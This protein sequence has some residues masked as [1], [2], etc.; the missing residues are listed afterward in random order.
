MKTKN[1]FII[2]ER[3]MILFVLITLFLGC[4]AEKECKTCQAQFINVNTGETINAEADCNRVP[5]SEGF[6][7][8]KCLDNPGY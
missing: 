6:V 3:I 7:F 8:V 4:S 5:P 2:I 1:P